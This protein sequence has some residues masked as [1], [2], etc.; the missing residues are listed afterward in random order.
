MIATSGPDN[1]ETL[2]KL[3]EMT[4]LIENKQLRPFVERVL[5]LEQVAED[6]RQLDSGHGRG[7]LVLSVPKKQALAGYF[8]RPLPLPPLWWSS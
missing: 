6:H 5:P 2:R 3:E 8:F 1:L 7:R 4:V